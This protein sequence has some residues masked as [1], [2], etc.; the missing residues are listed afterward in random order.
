MTPKT[1]RNDKKT[2]REFVST[3]TDRGGKNPKRQCTTTKAAA[4]DNYVPDNITS[5]T[6]VSSSRDNAINGAGWDRGGGNSDNDD[7]EDSNQPPTAIQLSKELC[8]IV[9]P[10]RYSNNEII[11]SLEK[12][13]IWTRTK[14]P[15]FFN[16]FDGNGGITKVL[17]FMTATMHNS[18]CKGEIRMKFI[19]MAALVILEVCGGG[20]ENNINKDI[21][22]K[23][24]ISA[25]DYNIMNVLINA[26]E[27]YNGGNDQFEL[28]A[29]KSIWR[30]FVNIFRLNVEMSE[31]QA[32][33][34]FGTGIDLITHLKYVDGDNAISIFQQVFCTFMFLTKNYTMTKKFFK[35]KN[36]ISKCLDVLKKN[37]TTWDCRT[38]ELMEV[39]MPFFGICILKRIFDLVLDYEQ[40][41]LFIIVC[42]KKFSS[43]ITIQK[44]AIDLLKNT[45]DVL[46][47]KSLIEKAGAVA[48]LGELL[49]SN[50][51]SESLKKKVRTLIRRI[52]AP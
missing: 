46:S 38:V 33:S 13:V 5:N 1:R 32:F 37:N 18:N 8:R 30:A 48:F 10:A 2:K 42:A 35:D 17:D 4:E 51:A 26:T 43:D 47:D 9:D 49:A 19:E 36:I 41:L 29:V 40:V 31:D 3:L 44:H 16:F 39:V 27:E 20:L 22:M 45:C 11:R 21:V 50:C 12:L 34:V 7:D 28:R 25:M 24:A 23:I 15:H 52:T 14:D 6:E